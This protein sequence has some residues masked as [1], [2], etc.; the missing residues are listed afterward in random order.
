MWELISNDLDIILLPFISAIIGWGTNVL[1]LKMTFYPLEFI[2][3][4]F[5]G[6][7]AIGWA[8]LPPIGWQG[9]I[10]SKAES[11]ASKATD[12]ITTKLIDVEDQFARINPTIVAKEMESSI[13]R[14]A[15]EVTNE[16]M[17]KHVPMW[18]LLPNS[19]KE[20]IYARAAEEIPSVIEEIMEEVKVNI[21]D[22]FDLKAMAVN[23][24][25][26]NK[27]L[28]N[29]I[30]LEVGD[31][32]FTFIERSGFVFGFIFGIFQAILWVYCEAPWQ[33]PV[34]GLLVGYL[35]NVLALRMIFSP[36]NPIHI[37]GFKIQGLFIKRQKEVSRGYAQLVS[38]NVMTM[39]N[40]FTQMFK[41]A[42][43]DKLVKII[44]KH[45]KEGI[46]KTAGFNSSLIKFTSGTDTYDEIKMIAVN[47]FI[48]AAP[49]QIHI[50]FD[51]AKQALDIEETMYV[52]M[53]NL[54]P[55]EFVNFLRPVF[56]EDEWKLI[57]TGAI[58][59][60]IAGCLQLLLTTVL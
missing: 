17:T 33:L 59:G 23:H 3:F 14:L 58:L 39:D 8:G 43:A 37:F 34:G 40:V 26:N 31:K 18:K 1:A 54:P 35:T 32:E 36:T 48:E 27:D 15:R 4:K 50:V 24:L 51:Y 28:L 60:M 21:T 47:R 13:L 19:Q 53:T 12:M 11:M 45:S 29:R 7:K 52:R 56:Q 16:V 20:K 25:T 5:E 55:D 46:D 49:E 10:P 2:G 38:E 41:G 42:G 9:I 22:V 44:E 57:L 6:I 30:F